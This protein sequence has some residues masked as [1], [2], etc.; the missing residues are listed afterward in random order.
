MGINGKRGRMGRGEGWELTS[1][2][3]MRADVTSGMPKLN[4]G[5]G[6]DVKHA[7]S[8]PEREAGMDAM[9]GRMGSGEV[10]LAGWE[11]RKDVKR[12]WMGHGE[13][14]EVGKCGWQDGK[15]GRM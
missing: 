15:R 5:M 1:A 13:R 6:A 9:R 2:G 11:A 3:R 7:K 14:R 4:H 12:G 10:W 8:Q